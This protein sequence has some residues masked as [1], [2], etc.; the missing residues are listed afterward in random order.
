MKFSFVFQSIS[1]V[2]LYFS[3]KFLVKHTVFI[4][5][6]KMCVGGVCMC[7]YIVKL[8]SHK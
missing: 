6:K 8:L 2:H 3:W 5:F 7:L 4:S 1:S